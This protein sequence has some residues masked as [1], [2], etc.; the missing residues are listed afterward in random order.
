MAANFDGASVTLKC[1]SDRSLAVLVCTRD[2]HVFQWLPA[3]ASA[4][5]TSTSASGYMSGTAEEGIRCEEPICNRGTCLP[6]HKA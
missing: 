6:A 3:V 5:G 4:P 2:C 1:L